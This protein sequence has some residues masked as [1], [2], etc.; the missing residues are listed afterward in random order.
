MKGEIYQDGSYLDNNP[1]WD[2]E[3]SP[4]KVLQINKLLEKNDINPTTI[5]EVG[6]GAGEIIKQL[7]ISF[8]CKADSKG[9]EISKQAYEIC[10]KKAKDNLS[11]HLED[12]TKTDEF[13]DLLLVIDVFEHVDDY[14]G[15]LRKLHKCAKYKVFHIPL[16]MSVQSVFRVSPILNA[17]A[18]VGHLHYFNKE[19][20]LMSLEYAGYKI[21]DSF[22]TA[23]GIETF[24]P[25]FGRK[26]LFLP[27]KLA[28]YLN[29]DLAA[30]IFGGFSLMVLTE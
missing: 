15:F 7:W 1:T 5:G 11:Y 6:C 29:Q 25:G 9:F 28:Y 22:F 17:R 18:K 20:A 23:G 16:D 14:I 13:F 19:T 4:W 26:A 8:D 24:R 12:I 2:I 30:R 10:K 21:I 27:R 3:D